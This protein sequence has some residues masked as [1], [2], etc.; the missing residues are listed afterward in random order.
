MV[1]LAGLLTALIVLWFFLFYKKALLKT[2]YALKLTELRQ[3]LKAYVAEERADTNSWAVSFLD[4][5][6][7]LASSNLNDLNYYTA[8]GLHAMHAKDQDLTLFVSKLHDELNLPSN[9]ALRT[10]YYKF[11]TIVV[12]Y[13]IKKHKIFRQIFL[14][15]H[16]LLVYRN[17]RDRRKPP[18]LILEKIKN[19]RVYPETSASGEFI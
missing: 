8:W 13:V 7:S 11:G 17:N 9:A 16:H 2:R 6:I 10:I 3:E 14:K 12:E 4:K 5:S 1:T 19:F 15:L 18:S